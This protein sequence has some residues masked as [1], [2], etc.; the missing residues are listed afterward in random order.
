MRARSST[1]SV[2]GSP[3]ASIASISNSLPAASMTGSRFM[4]QVPPSTSSTPAGAP[5]ARSRSSAAM[6]TPSSAMS[7][8]PRPMTTV[9][10]AGVLLGSVHI[11]DVGSDEASAADDRGDRSRAL[12]QIGPQ[13]QIDVHRDEDQEHPRQDVMD[14]V[15]DLDAAEHGDDPPEQGVP[16]ASRARLAVHR[17]SSD[18]LDQRDPVQTGVAELLQRVVPQP[19]RTLLGLDHEV[20]LHLLP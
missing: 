17:E 13:R 7:G 18:G 8:L 1:C 5:A 2:P 12:Q 6:P 3:P 20:E 4:P 19:L 14:E 15:H 16:E 11:L 10:P 9:R